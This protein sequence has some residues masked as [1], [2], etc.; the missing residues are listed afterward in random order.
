MI[1]LLPIL[2]VPLAVACAPVPMTPE[3]AARECRADASQAD[4]IFG[5][6]GVGV[7]NRGPV[8]D[9]SITIT[10]RV[11]NP[12]SEEEFVAECIARRMEGRP[13]PTT[14]G[15]SVGSRR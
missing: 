11:F 5:S 7:S 8:G 3:R 9:G 15:V 6:V 2:V 13:E 12:Q 10:N 4:G 1:R 14:F